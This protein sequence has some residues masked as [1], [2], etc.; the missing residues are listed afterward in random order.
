MRAGDVIWNPLTG[1]KALIVESAQETGGA[2]IVARF[3]VEEGG[4]VPGGE[5]RHNHC[6]EHFAV[7]RGEITFL[8]DGREQ[9]LTGGQ[10]LMVPRGAWHRWWN[11]G[12]GQVEI[13]V[14]VEP[15]LRIAE[16]I[17]V[18]W[19]LCADGHTDAKGSPSPLL[20]ALLATRY[21][22][23]IELREP[24]APVQRLLFPPLAAIGRVLGKDRVI[25]GYL[26]L[27]GH[28]AAEPG[29]GKLPERVMNAPA[30]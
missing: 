11:S 20:G 12:Q 1:E 22:D 4:F 17:A 23:E 27:E 30:G 15:A 24:P 10:E 9:T 28:P 21:S 29:L 16:V 13:R 5:H 18:I 14:T 6:S 7:E 26:D 8:V 2:R 19:G 25:D 3:A